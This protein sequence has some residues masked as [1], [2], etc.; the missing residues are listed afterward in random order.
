MERISLGPPLSLPDL[1]AVAFIKLQILAQ[2]KEFRSSPWLKNS[3]LWL[4][5]ELPAPPSAGVTCEFVMLPGKCFIVNG[6]DEILREYLFFSVA[7]IHNKL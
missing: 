6:S 2:V 1:S 4:R 3:P 7:L 5:F